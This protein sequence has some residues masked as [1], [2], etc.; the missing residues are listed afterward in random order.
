[1][2][3]LLRQAGPDEIIVDGSVAQFLDRRFAMEAIGTESADSFRVLGRERPRFEVSG[4]TL[5]RFVGRRRD[6]DAL[7]ELLKRAEDGQAQI[8][9]LVGEAGIG[10]SRL[11]FELTHAHRVKDWL[12]L[13][14]TS[15]AH[16]QATSYL[17]VAGLLRTYFQIT[18]RDT[19]R[20]ISEKVT[21][22]ILALDRALEPTLAALLTL[23]DVA[24]EE[25]AW[26]GLD[27]PGR[28]RRMLEAVKLLLRREAQVR[29]LL[30]IV[31]D[32]HWIDTETQALLDSLT[33]S[34]AMGPFLL[35]VSYRPEY[36]HGWERTSNYWVP[37][38]VVTHRSIHSSGSSRRQRGAIVSAPSPTS[39]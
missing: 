34:V 5:S 27:P 7:L 15:V 12:V 23:L 9:G 19:Q 33:E 25:P 26:R 38:S 3:A 21:E 24:V 29:P 18:D 16:G 14:A 6:L 39:S 11:L 1:M 22:K 2:S 20:D 28:R 31:E 35:L 36:R 4:P 37:C 32:L 17:P 10:K 13:E 30:V 8:V